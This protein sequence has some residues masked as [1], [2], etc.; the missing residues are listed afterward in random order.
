[1]PNGSEWLR[2]APGTSDSGRIVAKAIVGK[3]AWL[4][5]RRPDDGVVIDARP[6]FAASAQRQPLSG[7]RSWTA[8]IRIHVRGS[9]SPEL[10][11]PVLDG[12]DLTV[13]IR[14][15]EVV[16]Q[17]SFVLEARQGTRTITGSGKLFGPPDRRNT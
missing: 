3:G 7:P 8:V 17:V 10:M 16:H 13:S 2:T 14:G 15:I 4:A 12:E 9:H 1:M 5:H 11:D 6:G